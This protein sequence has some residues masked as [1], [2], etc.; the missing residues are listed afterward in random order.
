MDG[1]ILPYFPASLWVLSAGVT[2]I[3]LL[4]VFGYYVYWRKREAALL[5]GVADAAELAAK[6][7]ILQA[8]MEAIRQWMDYQK[9]ELERLSAEREAQELVRAHL[10]DLEQQ[11]ATKDQENQA[12]RN[13][14]GELENQ[15]HM[16]TQ[17]LEKL[18]GE[19]AKQQ[20]EIKKIE[21]HKNEIERLKTEAEAQRQIVSEQEKTIREQKSELG[22]IEYKHNTLL[23][24]AEELQEKEQQYDLIKSKLPELKQEL[25]DTREEL[26]VQQRLEAETALKVH[27][28]K[29]ELDELEKKKA[30]I[31]SK[32]E[33]H[34]EIEEKLKNIKDQFTD[35]KQELDDTKN[36]ILIQQ[37][38]EDEVAR[39]VQEY[40]KLVDELK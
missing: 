7:Q 19:I 14:V 36:E 28:L 8:D 27:Q 34:E 11:C 5:E 30:K 10:A 24:K 17:T 33:E 22:D 38:L 18:E 3:L 21:A 4:V 32:I 2:I 12:L 39:K 6:K 9:A 35:L 1:V 15:R 13:E 23:K 29:S 37:R 20:D 31:E 40:N 25:D 26:S 16:T